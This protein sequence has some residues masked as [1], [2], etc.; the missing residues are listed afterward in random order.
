VESTKTFKEPIVTEILPL[1]KFYVAEEY[2]QDFYQKEPDRYHSYRNG[3]GRDQRLKQL[4]GTSA[5]H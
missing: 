2:H 4:W 1:T 3:C 5:G